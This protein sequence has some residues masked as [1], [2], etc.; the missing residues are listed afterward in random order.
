MTSEVN[1][2]LELSCGIFEVSTLTVNLSPA[3][4]SLTFIP[5][6]AVKTLSLFKSPELA[7]VK[8]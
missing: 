7:S 6:P 3:P 5:S 2:L 8:Y 4:A 1:V